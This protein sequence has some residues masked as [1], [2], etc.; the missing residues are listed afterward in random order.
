MGVFALRTLA[1]A[2][3]IGVTHDAI[4]LSGF[5]ATRL[6]RQVLGPVFGGQIPNQRGELRYLLTSLLDLRLVFRPLNLNQVAGGGTSGFC[7]PLGY[8]RRF[9]WRG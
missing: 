7:L 1:S 6:F 9:G 3:K 4:P 5:I 8:A 2:G